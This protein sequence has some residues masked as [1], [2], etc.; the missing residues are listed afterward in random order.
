MSSLSKN[1]IPPQGNKIVRVITPSRAE[2]ILS[3]PVQSEALLYQYRVVG[4]TEGESV[5][6]IAKRLKEAEPKKLRAVAYQVH[7]RAQSQANIHK[8]A[9]PQQVKEKAY[10]S[11]ARRGMNKRDV[12]TIKR[13]VSLGNFRRAARTV[14]AYKRQDRDWLKLTSGERNN[15]IQLHG[16]RLMRDV[17]ERYR[18]PV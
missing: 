2:E 9:S 5:Q 6:E 7:K 10:E 1:N 13:K 16:E 12:K 11:L 8:K 4:G 18:P 14:G 15:I 17:G 3:G